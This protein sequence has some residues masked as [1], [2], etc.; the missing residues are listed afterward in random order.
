MKAEILA[1]VARARQVYTENLDLPNLLADLAF[2]IILSED[3]HTL[4]KLLQIQS[5]WVV[6]EGQISSVSSYSFIKFIDKEEALEHY[7]SI[8]NIILNYQ[9]KIPNWRRE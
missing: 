3:Q 4:K 8:L 5:R 9:D 1:C 7:D 2:K 6:E